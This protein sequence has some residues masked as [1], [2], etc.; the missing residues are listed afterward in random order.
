MGS[1]RSL[2]PLIVIALLFYL[3][4]IRP[5][6]NRQRQTQNLL[7]KMTSGD[8]VLTSSGLYG[9]VVDLDGDSVLLEVSPGVEMRF[10]KGAVQRILA[11]EEDRADA[12]EATLLD[13]DYDGDVEPEP[14]P[15]HQAP[16]SAPADPVGT[17]ADPADQR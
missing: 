5:Q 10:V 1:L 14:A 11:P 6:R 7:S 13:E 2:L 12:G 17:N 9:T 4:L 16:R 8:R 15:G 3:L